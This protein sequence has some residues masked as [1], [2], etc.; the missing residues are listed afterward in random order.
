MKNIYPRVVLA[1]N[2]QVFDLVRSNV[3]LNKL[4]VIKRR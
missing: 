3:V 1:E 2:G 4:L